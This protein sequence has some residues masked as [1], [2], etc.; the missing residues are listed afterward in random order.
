MKLV[1]HNIIQ[2][3]NNVLWDWQYYAEYGLVITWR[4]INSSLWPLMVFLHLNSAF[5]PWNDNLF[6][7]QLVIGWSNFQNGIFN[8]TYII[9]GV[10]HW[11]KLSFTC[12]WLS[13]TSSQDMW[14]APNPMHYII[15][16]LGTSAL[17]LGILHCH[18]SMQPR[19]ALWVTKVYEIRRTSR[20]GQNGN[21]L[22]K[23][24]ANVNMTTRLERL[25]TTYCYIGK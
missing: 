16:C 18:T 2:I 9:Y 20:W 15:Y 4:F 1:P 14:I 8:S 19:D 6:Y 11:P 24:M 13:K 23:R 25:G 5:E 12:E 22:W 7:S 3:H 21:G 10:M 17:C